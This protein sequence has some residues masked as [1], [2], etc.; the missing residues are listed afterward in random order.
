MG[1]SL[2]ILETDADVTFNHGKTAVLSGTASLPLICDPRALVVVANVDKGLFDSDSS[3]RLTYQ[4]TLQSSHEVLAH[5]NFS[6]SVKK[7][8]GLSPEATYAIRL[9]TGDAVLEHVLVT[10]KANSAENY[11]VTDFYVPEEERYDISDVHEFVSPSLV[12]D[13][14]TTGDIVEVDMGFAR[15]T[16]VKTTFVKRGELV[17]VDEVDAVLLPFDASTTETQES[18][19]LLSDET[20]VQVSLDQGSG[21]ISIGGIIRQNGESF[22]MDGKKVTVWDIRCMLAKT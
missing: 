22:I 11:D 3:F 4:M 18:T 21:D 16:K 6:E 12:N 9:Y 13:I 2:S 10:T 14:F 5:D 15:P 19:L 8:T 20:S 7:I 1:D 17:D